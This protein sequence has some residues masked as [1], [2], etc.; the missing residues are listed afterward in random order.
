MACRWRCET[1]WTCRFQRH[2]RGSLLSRFAASRWHDFLSSMARGDC[3]STRVRS[4]A[5]GPASRLG[6]PVVDLSDRRDVRDHHARGARAVDEVHRRRR[7]RPPWR[8]PR[9]P[10][11]DADRGH[12]RLS[13]VPRGAVTRCRGA[14]AHRQPARRRADLPRAD[15]RPRRRA[16]GG[17]RP[18]RRDPRQSS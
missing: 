13:P 17:P 14:A 8:R 6:V 2:R 12:R 5:P 3:A 10:D 16:A 18:W 7:P 9:R 4:D 1:V 11:P 15:H